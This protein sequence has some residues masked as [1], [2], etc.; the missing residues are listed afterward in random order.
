M[1][2]GTLELTAPAPLQEQEYEQV[3]SNGGLEMQE[4]RDDEKHRGGNLALV[5]ALE[6]VISQPHNTTVTSL[7]NLVEV[8]GS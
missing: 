5:L 6:A 2:A 7:G 4:R 8:R 1:V 3:G